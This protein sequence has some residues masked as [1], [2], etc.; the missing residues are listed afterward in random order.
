MILSDG[1]GDILE[2]DGLAG[3]RGRDDQRALSF[4]YGGE[5]VDYAGREIV[6]LTFA[7]FEFFVG[8]E[9]HEMLEGYAVTHVGRRQ[10]IDADDVA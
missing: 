5:H 9:G 6:G 2:Q 3:L 1:V 4:A 7:E 10:T 8:E